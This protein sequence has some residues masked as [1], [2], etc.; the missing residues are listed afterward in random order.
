MKMLIPLAAASAALALGACQTMQQQVD[1]KEDLLAA[2]GFTMRMADTPERPASL[3]QLPPDKVVPKSEKGQTEY[4]Y[5]DP[6]VCDCLYVGNT[7]AYNAYKHELF[8]KKIADQ[9]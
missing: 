4:V 9:Q 8:V 5:A 1:A 7:A 6:K 3:Q 2:A